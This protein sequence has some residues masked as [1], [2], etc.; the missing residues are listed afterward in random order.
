MILI[1]HRRT[2]LEFVIHETGLQ[3]RYTPL[4]PPARISFA[5]FC[6]PHGHIPFDKID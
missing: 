6:N 3:Q 1:L 5:C 4:K 2:A